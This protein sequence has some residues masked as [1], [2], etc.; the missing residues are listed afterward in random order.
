MCVLA[1]VCKLY[2]VQANRVGEPCSRPESPTSII[3]LQS[4]VLGSSVGETDNLCHNMAGKH[5]GIPGQEAKTD[6][7]RDAGDMTEQEN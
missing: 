2:D 6:Q 7:K 3:R 1:K 5:P 4:N